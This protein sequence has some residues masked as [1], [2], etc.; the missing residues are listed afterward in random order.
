MNSVY[1][2]KQDNKRREI[3]EMLDSRGGYFPLKNLVRGKLTKSVEE[4]N[5]K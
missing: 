2:I 1:I 3:Q 4:R 5:Y